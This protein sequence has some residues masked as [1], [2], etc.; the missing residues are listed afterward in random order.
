MKIFIFESLST[1]SPNYHSEGGL[2]VVAKDKKQVEEL[3]EKQ[4]YIEIDDEEWQDVLIYEL[5]EDAE[6]KVFVFP[7]AGCC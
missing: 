5:K 2:A 1:V 4:Q 6:P 7:D 3:I